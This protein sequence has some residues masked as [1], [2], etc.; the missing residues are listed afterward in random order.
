MIGTQPGLGDLAAAMLEERGAKVLVR[1]NDG[2]GDLVVFEGL[3]ATET[4]LPLAEDVFVV[5]GRASGGRSARSVAERLFDDRGWQQ[6]FAIAQRHGATIGATTGFRVIVRVGSER[7][8]KRTELRTSVSEVVSRWRPRWRIKDPADVEV[9]V[10][11]ATPGLFFAAVRLSSAEMRS[12]GGRAVERS[13]S[14]RP[15]VAAAMVELAGKPEG[16]LVDPFCGSGTILGE[17]RRAGWEV[18]GL[19]IDPAAVEASTANQPGVD[20]CLGDAA[21]LPWANREAAAVVTNAPFGVQHIPQLGGRSEG[22]WWRSVLDELARVVRPGG[23]VVLLH[24]DRRRFRNEV[25]ATSSLQLRARLPI[26]TLGQQATIWSL[27]RLGETTR[28]D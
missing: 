22:E 23:T 25:N 1:G 3:D 18:A 12:R 24:P 27:S 20:V 26:Q 7:A 19:D 6:G 17:A 8:F 28:A 16:L 21:D 13:G 4:S 10:L 5:V 9:W 11:E 15:V 2:R 14:L